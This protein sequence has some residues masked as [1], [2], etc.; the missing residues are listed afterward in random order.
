MDRLATVLTLSEKDR[1]LWRG[2]LTRYYRKTGDWGSYALFP[3]I[4]LADG[5][6]FSLGIDIGDGM[7][8]YSGEM[9]RRGWASVLPIE[10]GSLPQYAASPGLFITAG[11]ARPFPFTPGSV[12]VRS[13]ALV[14]ISE[15]SF[16]ILRERPLR[17]G[18]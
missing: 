3:A 10:D 11:Q 4:I 6:F 17:K 14:R 2:I 7:Y 1:L 15:G 18:R 13:L 16:R 12:S 8:G 5:D 9:A